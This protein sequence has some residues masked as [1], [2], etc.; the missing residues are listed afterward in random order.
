[1]WKLN[2]DK[3]HI[4]MLHTGGHEVTNIT[5]AKLIDIS[6]RNANQNI[7]IISLFEVTIFI[8]KVGWEI[9]YI[10]GIKKVMLLNEV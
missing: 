8:G 6:R 2:D 9:I 10:D 1:M 5:H 4:G 7:N 3:R